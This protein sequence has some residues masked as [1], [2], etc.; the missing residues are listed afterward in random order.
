LEPSTSGDIGISNN[1]VVDVSASLENN[2]S[3]DM[4]INVED[5]PT[6][7]TS[8]GINNIQNT[9]SSSSQKLPEALLRCAYIQNENSQT[10]VFW[11]EE[12]TKWS[13]KCQN[14]IMADI[15]DG[16]SWV[17][18]EIP[19]G[20]QVAEPLYFLYLHRNNI[21]MKGI[22]GNFGIRLFHYTL[23]TRFQD[24]V[25]MK[26]T[27]RRIAKNVNEDCKANLIFDENRLFLYK[28]ACV[29]SNLI[30]KKGAIDKL[31]RDTNEVL[32]DRYSSNPRFWDNNTELIKKFFFINK[33]QLDVAELL[34]AP[35]ENIDPCIERTQDLVRLV[36]LRRNG[37]NAVNTSQTDVENQPDPEDEVIVDNDENSTTIFSAPNNT[38][39]HNTTET[40][41]TNDDPEEETT[42]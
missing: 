12:L 35:L 21:Y 37:I 41:Y 32:N 18:R 7:L 29:W 33:L 5:I 34:N 24:E 39:Q 10:V 38:Q 42:D 4:G 28:K 8:N 17:T 36:S 26:N 27:A 14:K 2:I 22:H 16:K 20:S 40:I 23:R 15:R 1:S 31:I 9:N 6:P 3:D 25:N 19:F 13:F 11:C 30:G